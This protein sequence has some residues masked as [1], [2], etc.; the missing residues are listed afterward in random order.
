MVECE[1]SRASREE[2]EEEE[3]TEWM[4]C[5]YTRGGVVT[6]KMIR[7]CASWLYD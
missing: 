6:K 7:Y 5:F 3:E 1:F 4:N 2:E